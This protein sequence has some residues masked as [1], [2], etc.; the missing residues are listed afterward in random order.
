MRHDPRRPAV[1][2]AFPATAATMLAMERERDTG[3]RTDQAG[4]ACP[5]RCVTGAGGAPRS[6]LMINGG[7]LPVNVTYQGKVPVLPGITITRA[8]GGT[9]QGYL[10]AAGATAFGAV[11]ARQAK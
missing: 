10:T 8:R 4:S 11:L 3:Q 1:T 7:R 5:R 2:L 6:I 9:A